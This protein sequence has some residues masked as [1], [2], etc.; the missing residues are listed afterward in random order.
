MLASLDI[1]S[2]ESPY[3]KDSLRF[4]LKVYAFFLNDQRP[5]H[6]PA[7]N[8]DDIL[9]HQTEKDQYHRSK[10]EHPCYDRSNPTE[11]LSHHKIFAMR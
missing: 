1:M 2:R 11:K 9:S 4:R 10:K 7:V 6:E 3:H 5:V 8:A